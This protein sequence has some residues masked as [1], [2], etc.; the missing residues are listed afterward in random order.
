MSVFKKLLL[1]S[2]GFLVLG[3]CA[4]NSDKTNLNVVDL[5]SSDLIAAISGA[6]RI[7][8]HRDIYRHPKETLG[9]FEIKPSDKV[10]EIW[11][12]QGWYS[13]IIAPYLKNGNG[14]YI[15]ALTH[16]ENPSEQTLK[17]IQN[18]KDK[19]T[20][21]TAIYGNVNITYFGAKS[22]ELSV[23][24]SVD[25]VLTFRNIHNWM[26]AGFAEKAFKDFYWVLKP[27]GVLGVVEHRAN[28]DKPQDLKAAD[29]YV[30]EDYVI[31]LATKAGFKLVSSSSVNNN[32]KDTKDHPFGVW[33]LPPNLRTSKFGQ[34][35]NPDFDSS[36]YKEIGESDRMTLKFVKPK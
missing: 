20:N 5:N 24:N 23:P 12:G 21:N 17:N 27:G 11:P 33:T 22:P 18:F 6:Q 29:G 35:A 31:E 8:A 15:A 34:P 32:P 26:G 10:L 14:E 13:T 4:S 25:K 28:N 2:L 3:S 16:S 36:K 9:F 1:G 19:F 30:R 7:D